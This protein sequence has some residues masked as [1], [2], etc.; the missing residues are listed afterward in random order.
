MSGTAPQQKGAYRAPF[1]ITILWPESE[2]DLAYYER[3]CKPTGD[4]FGGERDRKLQE[5]KKQEGYYN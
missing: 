2:E 1:D 3:T 4:K 5:F